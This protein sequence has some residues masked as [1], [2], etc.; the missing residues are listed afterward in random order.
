MVWQTILN[1]GH[2]RGHLAL[3][4]YYWWR[5]LDWDLNWSVGGVRDDENDAAMRYLQTLRWIGYGIDTFETLDSAMASPSSTPEAA[6]WRWWA[7]SAS[8]RAGW[9]A[10]CV[11]RPIHCTAAGPS[12]RSHPSTASSPHQPSRSPQRLSPQ[13][14]YLAAVVARPAQREQHS[15]AP[16]PG[17]EPWPRSRSPADPRP[18]DLL[19]IQGAVVRSAA[20][21]TLLWPGRCCVARV[22]DGAWHHTCQ[23]CLTIFCNVEY[24]HKKIASDPCKILQLVLLKNVMIIPNSS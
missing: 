13:L 5:V 3:S 8:G 9:R 10:G 15:M 22:P 12:A 7:G 6:G 4:S 14:S 20:P 19:R 24:T 11:W 17:S 2:S 18:G 21:P 16:G 23:R 1:S